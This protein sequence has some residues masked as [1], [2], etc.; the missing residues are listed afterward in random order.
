M[1]QLKK[2]SIF[3]IISGSLL[4]AGTTIGAGM[5]AIPL[6]TGVAGFWPA[7]IVTTF[8]WLYMLLTGLLFLEATLWMHRGA[9]VLSM[10]KRFIGE[11]GRLLAGG[12]FV[13]L[14]IIA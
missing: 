9:N 13:F 3:Q 12:T 10:T 8:V 11:K 2:T 6:V 1:I 4:I 7:S 5:L 14:C